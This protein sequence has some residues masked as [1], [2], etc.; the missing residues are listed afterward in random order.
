[1]RAGTVVKS[2]GHD[3]PRQLFYEKEEEMNDKAAKKLRKKAFGS[4]PR[5]NPFKYVVRPNGEIR[6]IGL[7]ARYLNLKKGKRELLT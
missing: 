1:M 7:R 4:S 2:P 6:C 3:R 5:H